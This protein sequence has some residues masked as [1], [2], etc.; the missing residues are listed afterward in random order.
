MLFM[1]L[2]RVVY[3]ALL[4]L[5]T[6]SCVFN[7]PYASGKTVEQEELRR[8][9]GPSISVPQDLIRDI[10]AG[11]YPPLT[12][13]SIASP[14]GQ[15]GRKFHEGV[16]MKGRRGDPVYAAH[17]GVVGI[18][19]ERLSGYGEMIVLKTEN[20]ITV[21]GHLDKILVDRGERVKKGDVIGRVGSTGDASGPHL[22]FEIRLKPKGSNY[23]QSVDPEPFLRKI[24]S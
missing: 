23:Y 24:N 17:D 9:Q 2:P 3:I 1:K 5:F 8:S 19:G 16:D 15:R 11:L 13:L 6:S 21:Y 20:F 4:T 14:F 12:T 7:R 10:A 18:S 22:H